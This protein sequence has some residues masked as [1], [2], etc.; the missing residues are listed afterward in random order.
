MTSPVPG[1]IDALFAATVPIE[2]G[3]RIPPGTPFL[4]YDP[5]DD[6]VAWYPHGS[7]FPL[8][9][10]DPQPPAGAVYH[11]LLGPIPA[12]HHPTPEQSPFVR[13]IR[14]NRQRA[15]TPID[16]DEPDNWLGVRMARALSHRP[17][18]VK[19]YGTSVCPWLVLS[20]D[21]RSVRHF[22]TWEAAIAFAT[23]EKRT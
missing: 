1:I 6:S 9:E 14:A 10:G 12:P 4:E 2:P 19:T 17:K 21:R 8:V 18:I 22:D 13:A 16:D 11:R 7:A 5:E 3:T 15:R 23:A 20:P